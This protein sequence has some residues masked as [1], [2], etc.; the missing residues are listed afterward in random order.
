MT[1][2]TA[3]IVIDT[4]EEELRLSPDTK[5][6]SAHAIS[7]QFLMILYISDIAEFCQECLNEEH[8]LSYTKSK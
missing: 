8:D 1:Q 6:R 2:L 5:N 3:L 7:H 4:S